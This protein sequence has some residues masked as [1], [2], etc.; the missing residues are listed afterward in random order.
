LWRAGRLHAVRLSPKQARLRRC[1]KRLARCF[2]DRRVCRPEPRQCVERKFPLG[3]LSDPGRLPVPYMTDD[4]VYPSRFLRLKP[5]NHA[6]G[7]RAVLPDTQTRPLVLRSRKVPCFV[8]DLDSRCHDQGSIVYEVALEAWLQ[9]NREDL[10]DQVTQCTKCGKRTVPVFTLSGRTELQCIC[11]D[12]PAVKLTQSPATAPDEPV[13]VERV[14][15]ARL[16][17]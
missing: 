14:R 17:P 8:V 5:A 12:D 9:V 15:T 11:C 1:S 6:P 7:E 2:L 13:A 4:G 16:K 10:M 3:C